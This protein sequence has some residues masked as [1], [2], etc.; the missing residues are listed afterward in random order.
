MAGVVIGIEPTSAPNG[1]YLRRR[2]KTQVALRDRAPV[3]GCGVH[4][5]RLISWQGHGLSVPTVLEAVCGI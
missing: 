4:G 1:G 2:A 3:L 5:Y